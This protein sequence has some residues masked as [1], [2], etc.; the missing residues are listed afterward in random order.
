M[1]ISQEPPADSCL[2]LSV[3]TAGCV[4]ET[5][6]TSLFCQAEVDSS[7]ISLQALTAKVTSAGGS[8]VGQGREA[9]TDC[10]E[11]ETK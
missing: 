10:S 4:E 11:G 3:H 5:V 2:G 9:G 7:A 1:S 8:P 6:L